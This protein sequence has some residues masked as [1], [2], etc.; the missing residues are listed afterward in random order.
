MT[1]DTH[2][3][4]DAVDT[5]DTSTN[6]SADEDADVPAMVPADPDEVAEEI[7]DDQDDSPAA[8]VPVPEPSDRMHLGIKSF[9]SAIKGGA[10]IGSVILLAGEPGAGSREFMYTSAM[11]NALY[12][13]DY[14]LFDLHYTVTGNA[15]APDGVHYLSVAYQDTHLEEE[16]ARIID[17]ELLEAA[18]PYI[19]F[20]DISESFFELT[21]LPR[22][23]Y[24]T[25]PQDIHSIG[26][27]AASNGV[28]EQL[29]RTIS[30]TA[31]NNLLV[32]DSLTALASAPHADLDPDRLPTFVRGLSRAAYAWEGVILVQ[33]N[34]DAIPQSLYQQLVDAADGTFIFQWEDGAELN[35]T[36]QVRQ[37]RGV[38]SQLEAED[39][40]KFE[41]EIDE[42]GFSISDV[43]TIQ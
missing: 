5:T 40:V 23:W 34:P 8:I 10:P 32:I 21:N 33:V 11:F 1:D 28:L 20:H 39:I 16:I 30:D 35:R 2:S 41:T 22:D 3:D 31:P 27:N 26:G 13:A 29:T 42:T 18:L 6:D 19:T 14:E 37:F 24:K 7:T 12:H 36:M 25:T 38:L 9:D 15:R 17:D 43:R 4:D